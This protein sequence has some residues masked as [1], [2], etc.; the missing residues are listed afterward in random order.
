MGIKVTFLGQE[1]ETK[2]G[3]PAPAALVPKDAVREENG[4]KIVFLLKENHVERRAVT[5]GGTRGADTEILAG[6]VAGD[7][8]VVR[9]PETLRD[10]Q[11][12]EVKK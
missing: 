8:V 10:G 3:E 4:K 12:V 5:T 2:K 7:T 1:T 6:L 11:A 9:G